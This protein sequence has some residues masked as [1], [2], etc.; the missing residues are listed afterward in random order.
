MMNDERGL[1]GIHHSSF[2]KALF[3]KRKKN[4]K[5][6]LNNRAIQDETP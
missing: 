5:R 2:K 3:E 4:Q 6:S 1:N